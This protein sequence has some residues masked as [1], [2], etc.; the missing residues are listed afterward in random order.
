MNSDF[1]GR[2]RLGQ[3]HIGKSVQSKESIVLLWKN[4]KGIIMMV[5]T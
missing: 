1:S 5:S 4:D 2:T 3:A